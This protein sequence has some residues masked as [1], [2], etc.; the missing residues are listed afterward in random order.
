ML[1]FKQLG[2]S[3]IVKLR[4]LIQQG[5]SHICNNTAGGIFMWRDYFKMEYALFDNTVVFK[6]SAKYNGVNTVFSVPMGNDILGG[7]KLVAEYCR[8]NNLPIAFYAV[9]ED[10]IEPLQSVL[11]PISISDNISN[12]PKSSAAASDTQD[13]TIYSNEDWSDYIYEAD[14]LK[15]LQ[16]RKYSGKRNHINKFKKEYE[17]W[18][19][20]EIT[21]CNIARV[22]DFYI[23]YSAGLD[24]PTKIALE[25]HYKTIEVLD[26]YDMYDLPGGLLRVNDTVV[27]FS[28]GEIKNDVLYIHT[29]KADT[30]YFGAYQVINNEFAKHFAADNIKYINREEDDGDLGLRFSKHSYYP[31]NVIPKYIVVLT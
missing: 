10:E 30:H 26:N 4:G 27:A 29:E 31:C 8:A 22:R 24:F 3:D 2:L 23:K 19:F 18:A 17:N 13:Y 12:A 28:I 11:R 25:D 5:F 15:S 7:I 1:E 14:A 6:A 21:A 20:E 16:G 9:T